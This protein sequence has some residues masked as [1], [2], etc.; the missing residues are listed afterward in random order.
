[1]ETKPNPRIIEDLKAAGEELKMS[2][3]ELPKTSRV[4]PSDLP[5]HHPMEK[6]LPK[7]IEEYQK[8]LNQELSILEK[9]HQGVQALEKKLREKIELLKKLQ[10]KSLEINK[11][12]KEFEEQMA[13]V[14]HE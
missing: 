10:A 11:E 6:G 4:T 8:E 13:L 7:K 3:A 12:L 1:M 9:K 14:K 2:A 5:F